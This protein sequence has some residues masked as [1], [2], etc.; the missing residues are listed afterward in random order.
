M[1]LCSIFIE[2]SDDY[3]K[4]MDKVDDIEVLNWTQAAEETS[5]KHKR[6]QWIVL[7]KSMGVQQLTHIAHCPLRFLSLG[8]MLLWE[9]T[10]TMQ[11]LICIPSISESSWHGSCT[12]TNVCWFYIVIVTK[13]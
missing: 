7:I 13:W 1:K 12:I 3:I 8:H 11:P 10:N 9:G 4:E 2:G 6:S 5:E